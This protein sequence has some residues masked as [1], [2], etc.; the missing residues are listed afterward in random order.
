MINYNMA[1]WQTRGGEYKQTFKPPAFC[2]C[3]G[4]FYIFPCG[5]AMW[6]G[7]SFCSFCLGL[8]M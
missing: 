1:M 6:D 8:F 4:R 7:S 3:K 5:Q 2:S